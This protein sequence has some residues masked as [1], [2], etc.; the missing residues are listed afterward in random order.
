[1][2]PHPL[3]YVLLLLFVG[4]MLISLYTTDRQ[5]KK[6]QEIACARKREKKRAKAMAKNRANAE[7]MAGASDSA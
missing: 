2:Q 7:N 6:N 4:V 1:M 3:F 5:I